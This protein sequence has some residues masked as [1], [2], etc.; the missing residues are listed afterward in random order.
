MGKE[1]FVFSFEIRRCSSYLSTN[2]VSNFDWSQFPFQENPCIP[3]SF[4]S[5]LR[6][7]HVTPCLSI[8]IIYFMWQEQGVY[9]WRRGK[10]TLFWSKVYHKILFVLL[11]RGLSTIN[12]I[13]LTLKFTHLFITAAS[14]TY[15]IHFRN[16]FCLFLFSQ[17]SPI[18]IRN[19]QSWNKFL[20]VCLQHWTVGSVFERKFVLNMLL[21]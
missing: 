4:N 9:R 6:N 14:I 21:F 20:V 13:R 11:F 12:Y 16:C 15:I 18:H 7:V 3:D 8:K 19:E 10:T 5:Y 2:T 17:P 1:R